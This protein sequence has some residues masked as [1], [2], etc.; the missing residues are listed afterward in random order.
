MLFIGSHV[1]DI[2]GFVSTH[3]RANG[4]MQILVQ[5]NALTDLL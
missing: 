4:N 3:F 1:I 5:A 2:V